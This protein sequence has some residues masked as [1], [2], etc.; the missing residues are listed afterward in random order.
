MKYIN[1]LFIF[2]KKRKI[3]YLLNIRF[4]FFY[5]K[6]DKLLDDK[7][8]DLLK[9]NYLF[10][11]KKILISFNLSEINNFLSNEINDENKYNLINSKIQNLKLN[12]YLYYE[13]LFIYNYFRFY[14]SFRICFLIKKKINNLI[15]E[16]Y[17]Y[18]INKNCEL[19]I[20]T[21]IYENKQYL[22]SD[23]PKVKKILNLKKNKL[24]KFYFYLY[25]NDR[26]KL[27]TY[28]DQISINLADL[29][30]KNLIKNRSI[31]IYG[32]NYLLHKKN[33][34]FNI[35]NESLGVFTTFK[36]Y[37]F[38]KLDKIN[39]ICYLNSFKINHLY[40][41]LKN[42]LNLFEWIVVKNKVDYLTIKN[43]KKNIR[44]SH[45]IQSLFKNGSSMMIQNL[46]F[47]LLI[48]KPTKIYLTG[49]DFYILG[50]SS[51][52]LYKDY[53]NKLHNISESVREH[54]IFENRM[55]I[56]NIYKYNFIEVDDDLKNI[57]NIDDENFSKLLD[58]HY[59][60]YIF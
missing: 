3:I 1:W 36:N 2:I 16:N 48:Y 47:D 29:Q 7:R 20:K 21:S 12:K 53:D 54:E 10:Y 31:Y 27:N 34:N 43:I 25:E 22:I 33:N 35:T 18:F 19:L 37:T 32:P 26:N 56:K 58:L 44:I 9:S 24:L 6:Y 60:K 40:N 52:Y 8:Y 41:E 28:I 42:N 4:V 17:K 23:H 38:S 13:L 39:K 51:N 45:S 14:G 57:L 46:I 59:R 11:A 49:I 15:L 55:L 5:L 50:S 30:F